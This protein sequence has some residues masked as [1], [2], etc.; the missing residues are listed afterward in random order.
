MKRWFTVAWALVLVLTGCSAAQQRSASST[1]NAAYLVTA[2]G[3]KLAAV[4]VDAVTQVHIAAN[5]GV[6]TLSGQAHSAQERLRYENAA[7][8]VNG[9]TGVRNELTVNP[10][11]EGLRGQATDAALTARISAAIA[12]Q[13]GVNAFHVRPSVH[14]GNVTLSG[15]ASSE[16][17]HQTILQ[18]VRAVP[19]V[20]SV[21]DRI[22]ITP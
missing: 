15:T 11:A 9:V 20:K 6:V 12:G 13:A 10:H 3:T 16:S 17:V 22:T 1:A 18:T 2:V 4:D 8:S 14:R 19:G 5:R 21:T 7:K